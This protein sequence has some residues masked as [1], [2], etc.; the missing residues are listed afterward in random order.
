[1]SRGVPTPFHTLYHKTYP[2]AWNYRT[3]MAAS[4]HPARLRRMTTT[5]RSALRATV[6]I[7]LALV[8][9]A[10]ITRP[11]DA[12]AHTP[13]CR[14]LAVDAALT[15]APPGATPAEVTTLRQACN[16]TAARHARTHS[17]ATGTRRCTDVNGSGMSRS[18]C[19]ALATAA[20]DR[21]VAAWAWSPALHE[22]YR[23][24]STWSPNAVNESSGACGLAQRYPCPWR[25]YGGTE[26]PSDDRV[27]APALE[28]A[29]NGLRYIAGRYGTPDR[30]LA[31]HDARGSY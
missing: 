1:M 4:G 22:L 5:H 31:Y 27:Y 14:Q 12:G 23:R 6:A 21:R 3:D 2:N 11:H 26:S 18:T 10:G 19:R 7:V 9:V 16:R 24:E 8:A 28:Q 20:V 30:A 29:R 25:Y 17:I 15:N 13:N